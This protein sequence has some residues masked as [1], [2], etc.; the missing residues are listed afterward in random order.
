M[1]AAQRTPVQTTS[2][3]QVLADQARPDAL[4]RSFQ[5]PA[6]PQGPSLAQMLQ[7][8]AAARQTAVV[9]VAPPGV[10]SPEYERY[11]LEQEAARRGLSMDNLGRFAPGENTSI[12]AYPGLNPSDPEQMARDY[13]NLPA[14]SLYNVMRQVQQADGTTRS[15]PTGVLRR[16]TGT[17]AHQSQADPEVVEHGFL[18]PESRGFTNSVAAT[19]RDVLGLAERAGQA[20]GLVS[21]DTVQAN[22]DQ[23]AIDRLDAGRGG[24]IGSALGS[25][26]AAAPLAVAGA[27]AAPEVAGATLAARLLGSSALGMGL[28]GAGE[29]AN[30]ATANGADAGTAMTDAAVSGAANTALGLITGGTAPAAVRRVIDALPAS[31]RSRLARELYGT[32]QEMA[33]HAAALRD[34]ADAQTDLASVQTKGVT[35]D[36]TAA[37]KRLAAAQIAAE[38]AAPK[39]S[40]LGKALSPATVGAI[41]TGA[42]LGAGGAGVQEL[43]HLID[44]ANMEGP[45]GG[46]TLAN[47]LMGAAFGG[48]E[49]RAPTIARPDVPPTPYH[50]SKPG[51]PFGPPTPADPVGAAPTGGQTLADILGQGQPDTAAAANDA[52]ASPVASGSPVSPGSSIF[53]PTDTGS[54]APA[55]DVAAPPP[56]LEDWFAGPLPADGV[57]NANNGGASPTVDLAA[58]LDGQGAPEPQT[59]PQM[60]DAQSP[61]LLSPEMQRDLAAWVERGGMPE[62]AN[63]DVSPVAAGAPDLP[64]AGLPEGDAGTP[65]PTNEN[66][67]EDVRRMEEARQHLDDMNAI[68]SRLTPTEA[69]ATAQELRA[70]SAA[71]REAIRND[72]VMPDLTRVPVADASHQIAA[73]ARMLDV[74]QRHLERLSDHID[75]VGEPA[76]A[77]TPRAYIKPQQL[78]FDDLLNAPAEPETP[79]TAGMAPRNVNLSRRAMAAMDTPVR[80]TALDIPTE[81]IRPKAMEA[82]ARKGAGAYGR[83]AEEVRQAMRDGGHSLAGTPRVRPLARISDRDLK[84]LLQSRNDNVRYVA[85]VETAYRNIED[86]HSPVT[87]R[88]MRQTIAQIPGMS[89]ADL[90]RIRAAGVAERGD[91]PFDRVVAATAE[92]EQY[93]RQ[94]GDAT[95]EPVKRPDDINYVDC[96]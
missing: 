85:T 71:L 58:L 21:P 19:G 96:E 18:G 57:A 9:P 30:A 23:A 28:P 94:V 62:P 3:Q 83:A 44:P 14:L 51:I 46:G 53:A 7:M 76:T 12:G 29:A 48:L 64:A 47:I 61:S 84:R 4:I 60:T 38:K 78:T 59:L 80:N 79:A 1:S 88:Y 40:L 74:I 70:R 35:A 66:R 72:G 55:N 2:P 81:R 95:G 37:E 68:V 10:A 33:D 13:A 92:Q 86:L 31:A 39:T 24:V 15:V 89:D 67:T 5:P 22:A 20:L 26:A 93:R 25:L 6:A 87:R 49:N 36:I 50:I 75:E 17:G 43:Q 16:K 32:P 27:A 42:G 73:N 34:V 69:M 45:T 52:G 41:A 63:S 90:S 91:S 54:A 11:L 56:S 8:A 77:E 65:T 82:A